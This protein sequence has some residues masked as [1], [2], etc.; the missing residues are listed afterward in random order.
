MELNNFLKIGE[1][2]EV[3]GKT[4]KAIIYSNKNTEYLNYNGFVLKNIGID[5]VHIIV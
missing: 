1:V 4:I 5:R 2:N 3:Q